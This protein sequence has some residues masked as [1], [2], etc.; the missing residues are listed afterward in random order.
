MINEYASITVDS[1]CPAG[2]QIQLHYVVIS[3]FC[4]LSYWKWALLHKAMLLRVH[5]SEQQIL[6]CI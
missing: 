2:I 3:S 1:V 6:D 5:I 4:T